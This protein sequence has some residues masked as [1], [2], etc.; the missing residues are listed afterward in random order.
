[1]QRLASIAACRAWRQTISESGRSLGLVPTMGAL[2]AGHLALVRESLSRCDHTLV[3]IFVNPTQF[4][5]PKDLAK[6]PQQLESDLAE[7]EAAGIDAVFLPQAA[8]MYAD[9]YRFRL[10]EARDSRLLC[11]AHRPGHFDGVLTVVLK[12][13]NITTPTQAFFGEK[14]FQQLN[15]IRDMAEALHLP[16]KIVPVATVREA[17]GLAMSSRNARLSPFGRALAPLLHQHL[18]SAASCDAARQALEQ[19][20]FSVD[21]VEEHWGRRF[22]AARIEDVRLIDNVPIPA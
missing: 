12:L 15:L 9:D 20:G 14:D 19:A 7:L 21:Y 18:S 8:E 22:A 11:G 13:F 4:D 1:M 6:Y 5:D 2:H 3:S 17:D 16:V 10:S